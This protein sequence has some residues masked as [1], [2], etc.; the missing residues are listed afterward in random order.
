M[1]DGVFRLGGAQAET[2]GQLVYLVGPHC[3]Q[4]H[5]KLS[6]GWRCTLKLP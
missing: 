5:A 1:I 4:F 6:T 2:L 3:L